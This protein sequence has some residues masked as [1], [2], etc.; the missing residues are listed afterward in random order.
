MEGLTPVTITLPP[1]VR[2][3]VYLVLVAA[4]AVLA[5]LVAAGKVDAVWLSVLLSVASALG[6][7]L[8]HANVTGD[9]TDVEPDDPEAVG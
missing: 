6:F 2:R 7:T 9:P 8:A 5:G 4:N 3:V 1:K